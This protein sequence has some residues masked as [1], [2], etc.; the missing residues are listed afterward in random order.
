M[1]YSVCTGPSEGGPVGNTVLRVSRW[2][3]LWSGVPGL[4]HWCP[5]VR[6]FS[7]PVCEVL[8]Q[9]P[10]PYLFSCISPL[11]F[12]PPLFAFLP[13]RPHHSLWRLG[14]FLRFPRSSFF[15][16]FF[17]SPQ[18]R[19]S[20]SPGKKEGGGVGSALRCSANQQIFSQTRSLSLSYP[21]VSSTQVLFIC[22]NSHESNVERPIRCLAGQKSWMS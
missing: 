22:D 20:L 17:R 6:P 21:I 16:C 14:V 4:A 5:A 2:C 7:S 12:T 18:Q 1:P 10:E 11:L 3:R 19:P 8:S 9:P 15:Y 13:R